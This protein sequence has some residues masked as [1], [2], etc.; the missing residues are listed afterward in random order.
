MQND[1]IEHIEI[2]KDHIS[3][4]ITTMQKFQELPTPYNIWVSGSKTHEPYLKSALRDLDEITTDIKLAEAFITH[5]Y[6][7]QK[8][9]TPD[10]SIYKD[11]SS[12]N[13][14]IL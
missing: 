6:D 8:N 13:L 10:R 9:K 1:I 11:E 14:P 3:E 5:F 2:I 7:C 4:M 12:C